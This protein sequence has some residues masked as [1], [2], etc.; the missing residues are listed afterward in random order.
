LQVVKKYYLL[1]L[2]FPYFPLTKSIFFSKNIEKKWR[3][4]PK[5]ILVLPFTDVMS[6]CAHFG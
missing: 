6:C 2:F 4:L 5:H 3:M 1:C